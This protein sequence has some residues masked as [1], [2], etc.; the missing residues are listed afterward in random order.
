MKIDARKLF[1]AVAILVCSTLFLQSCDVANNDNV[2]PR[3]FKVTMTVGDETT[4]SA[5]KT[6]T[7]GGAD[8]SQVVLSEIKLLVHH[9]ELETT[10]D[11]SL[12]FELNDVIVNLPLDGDTLQISAQQIPAGEYKELDVEVDKADI[13][14]P[15]LNDSTGYYSLAVTGTY[16]GE[17]FI[18]KSKKEFDHEFRFNPPIQVTDSTETITLNLSIAVNRWFSHADP[19]NPDDQERIEY[20]I[21]RSFEAY[22]RY[23]GHRQWHHGYRKDTAE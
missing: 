16:N 10:L 9:M 15:D 3:Q 19:T 14:D 1:Y 8:S 11:D 12:D 22:C 21:K 13:N 18:F 23:N 7:M 6:Q 4:S 20:N 5:G 17:P 2:S